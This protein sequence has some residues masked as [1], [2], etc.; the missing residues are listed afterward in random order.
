MFL[1]ELLIPTAMVHGVF[2]EVYGVGVLITGN[3][4]VGK[5]ESALELITRGHRL[6]AD[7]SV[8]VK[9][10]GDKLL[11]YSPENIRYF[12]E[13]RGLGIINVQQIYG[14][15]AIRPEKTVEIV[16]EL[17]RWQSG[18]EVERLGDVKKEFEVLGVSCPKFTIP[19]RPGRNIPAIIETAA[20]KFRL[21][22]TGYD[23]TQELIQRTFAP[24]K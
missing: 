24:K 20:R 14:P 21:D 16:V 12:M 5:S 4:G 23:A 3:A 19:V 10:M 1:N 17:Q 13:V 2:V 18:Q 8:I 9:N 22:Q 7:D 11:G 6:I 15:G